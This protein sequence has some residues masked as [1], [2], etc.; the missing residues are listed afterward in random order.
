MSEKTRRTGQITKRGDS[1]RIFVFN[2]RDENGKRRYDTQTVKGTK[3]D[4]QTA[5][6]AMLR[7]SDLGLLGDARKQTLNEYLDT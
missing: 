3:K 6:N 7:D 4:A 1:W 2:G 5:L